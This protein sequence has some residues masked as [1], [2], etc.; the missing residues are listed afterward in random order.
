VLDEVQLTALVAGAE[1]MIDA[2]ATV[3]LPEV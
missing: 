2:G 1:A 3:V